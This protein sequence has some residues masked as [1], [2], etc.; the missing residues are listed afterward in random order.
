MR[1]YTSVVRHRNSLP[2][3]RPPLFFENTFQQMAK[4]E[5]SLVKYS[6]AWY[7]WFQTLSY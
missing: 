4:L 7:T 5:L 2:P 1:T 6:S 3:P